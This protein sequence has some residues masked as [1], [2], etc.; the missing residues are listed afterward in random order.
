MFD[1]AGQLSKHLNSD[2]LLISCTMSVEVWKL[3]EW[4]KILVRLGGSVNERLKFKKHVTQ[5]VGFEHNADHRRD[6]LES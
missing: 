4:C 6:A 3:R 1:F 5:V 2:N